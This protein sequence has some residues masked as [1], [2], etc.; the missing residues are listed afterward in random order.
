[1]TAIIAKKK[2]GSYLAYASDLRW[3][4]VRRDSIVED[5]KIEDLRHHD[6]QTYFCSTA[7]IEEVLGVI[8]SEELITIAIYE[9]RFIAIMSDHGTLSPSLILNTWIKRNCER[10]I[11]A[12]APLCTEKNWTAEELQSE[13]ETRLQS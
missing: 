4:L 11:E 9:L 8:T 3:Q 6:F 1:M 2:P 12:F 7:E 13:L 5:W 10:F